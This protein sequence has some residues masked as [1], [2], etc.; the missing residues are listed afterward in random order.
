MLCRYCGDLPST[1]QWAQ[2]WLSVLHHSGR[3]W[4][5]TD[6]G[7]LCHFFKKGFWKHSLL[8]NLS[9]Q[10]GFDTCQ[11]GLFMLFSMRAQILSNA[12]HQATSCSGYLQG[13]LSWTSATVWLAHGSDAMQEMHLSL[14]EVG[15]QLKASLAFDLQMWQQGSPS[16]VARRA[17][18][19]R[20]RDR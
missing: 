2:H 19:T 14:W 13:A 12:G 18:K 7:W 8:E 20:A 5:C 16:P 9:R 10:K 1:K 17:A 11:K 3:S 15:L 4:N 6:S